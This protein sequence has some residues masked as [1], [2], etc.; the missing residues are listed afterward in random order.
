[1]LSV[2]HI[3][4]VYWSLA[5]FTPDIVRHLAYLMDIPLFFFISG[6][7]FKNT[8]FRVSVRTA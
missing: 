3:H 6:Y 4:T 8:T 2:I 1:M 7:L 5:P